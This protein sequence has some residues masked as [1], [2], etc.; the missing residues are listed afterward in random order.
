[1]RKCLFF[2]IFALTSLVLPA[3]TTRDCADDL[4][5][6]ISLPEGPV[7]Y[8]SLD[9]NNDPCRFQF[10]IVTDRTGGHRP[11][12]FEDG[13][14]KL[15]WLQ[16]EFVMSVGDLIEGYTGDTDELDRQWTEFTSFTAEL[17]MPFFYVPGNHDLTNPVQLEAWK[18]RF[19]HTWYHFVYRDVLF[20]CLNSE[21]QLR[22]SA[23]GTISD[24][25]YG[26]IEKTLADNPD[27]KWTLVFMHQP[28]W[29][30][31]DTKRWPDVEKLLA[32]RKH[33][34]FTGHYHSYT[35]Y[36]RNNGKYFVLATTGG[37]SSLRGPQMGEFDHVTWITM[38]E[39]G[40]IMAN[41]QLEGIWNE[42]VMTADVREYIDKAA[43]I[44]SV[45]IEPIYVEKDWFESGGAQ[46]RV[47][48]DNDQPIKVRL[49]E[50]FNWDLSVQMDKNELELPP[51]S[52]EL[53]PFVLKARR[54]KPLSDLKPV[55]IYAEVTHSQTGQVAMAVPFRFPIKP[56]LKNKALPIRHGVT[57]DGD[58][59]EWREWPWHFEA[60]DK[61]D[62][63]AWFNLG[64]DKNFLYLAVRVKDNELRLDPGVSPLR[65]DA[66]RVVL[67]GLP[68]GAAALST[69]TKNYADELNLAQS[70]AH[71]G[72]EMRV[73]PDV[74]TPAGLQRVCK[75]TGDGYVLEMAIP[76]FY[77]QER[78]GTR[79]KTFRLNVSVVDWDKTDSH[80]SQIHFQPDW[81]SRNNVMGSGMFFRD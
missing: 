24:E 1:M 66:I 46:I 52:V 36:E 13:I 79:W 34:V 68:M 54:P 23:R 65:Q 12:V 72:Q 30:L 78:Q 55:D 10:A 61:E 67:N 26:Y 70:P 80:S 25:Q 53:V 14:R 45:K 51:N 74:P 60:A 29:T 7:P 4:T 41:L 27:V 33:T 35:K 64:Y 18:K 9:L 20:L 8:T 11:G 32:T 62:V 69:G 42:D 63:E 58:L 39:Q 15:N 21:D 56:I 44:S 76:I 57:V 3:Q 19:G 77:L 37:G 81:T 73:L 17:Q 6:T 16:P 5:L 47:T 75:T 38:T 59:S 49:R 50:S 31:E 71:E 28:L 48:N 43:R 40:P 2:L 22:G